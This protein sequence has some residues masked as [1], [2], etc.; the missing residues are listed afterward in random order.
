MEFDKNKSDMLSMKSSNFQKILSWLK[1]SFGLDQIWGSTDPT[2][3]KITIQIH[4]I[5]NIDQN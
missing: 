2:T 4:G 1:Y 5:Q 3:E